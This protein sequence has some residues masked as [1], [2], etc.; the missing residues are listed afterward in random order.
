MWEE[1]ELRGRGRKKRVE[2]EREVREVKGV[3]GV[4]RGAHVGGYTR[5]GVPVVVRACGCMYMREGGGRPSTIRYDI[6]SGSCTRHR[7]DGGVGGGEADRVGPVGHDPQS[8]PGAPC[9]VVP[10]GRNA[11]LA[12]R[13]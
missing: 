5:W 10:V 13:A 7:G 1:E 9:K 3:H 2:R 6:A 4:C 8:A 11:Q 12:V